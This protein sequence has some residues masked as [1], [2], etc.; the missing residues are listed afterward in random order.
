M[1]PQTTQPETK[2]PLVLPKIRLTSNRILVRVHTPQATTVNGIHLPESMQ[3][4]KLNQGFVVATGPGQLTGDGD[5]R[6]P[7]SC[8]VYD[9]VQFNRYN[10]AETYKEGDLSW[11]LLKDSDIVGII[12]RYQS[13]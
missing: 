2:K 9:E 5:T 1:E 3:A 6:L 4:E 8:Q 10:A 13:T 12:G 7:M 11:A